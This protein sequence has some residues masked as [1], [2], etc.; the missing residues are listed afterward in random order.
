MIVGRPKLLGSFSLRPQVWRLGDVGKIKVQFAQP[1]YNY[2][3]YSCLCT[4]PT[5]LGEP[6]EGLFA[7]SLKI[8]SA[9]V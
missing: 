3:C 4:L 1:H 2:N 8:E 5:R 6:G 7:N 9:N